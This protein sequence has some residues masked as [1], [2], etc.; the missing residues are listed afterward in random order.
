MKFL[1]LPLIAASFA[2]AGCTSDSTELE[3]TQ[4]AE[5]E[6]EAAAEPKDE[7]MVGLT[8]A[9]AEAMAADRGLKVRIISVDG[10]NRPVTMDYL[11]DRVNFTVEQGKIVKVNRG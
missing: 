1:T 7:D 8:V 2:L 3:A 6:A 5:E 11:A 10:D 4:G 9:A